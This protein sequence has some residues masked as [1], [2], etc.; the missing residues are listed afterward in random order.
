M[1]QKSYHRLL[2][3]WGFQWRWWLSH[4]GGLDDVRPVEGGGLLGGDVEDEAVVGG[5]EDHGR[6]VHHE[7]M[8]G[9]QINT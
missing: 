2:H 4:D 8:R 9:F 1:F 6:G 5:Q 3:Q 7:L